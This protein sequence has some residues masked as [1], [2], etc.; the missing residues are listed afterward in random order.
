[1]KKKL[2][3]LVKTK[4]TLNLIMRVLVIIDGN[5]FSMGFDE[6]VDTR[7]FFAF[8]MIYHEKVMGPKM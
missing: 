4:V 5:R 1:M 6:I 7:A 2:R 8:G 3:K